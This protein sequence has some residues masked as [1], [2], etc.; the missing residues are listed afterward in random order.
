[1]HFIKLSQLLLHHVPVGFHRD[2]CAFRSFS[3]SSAA[4]K[5]EVEKKITRVLLFWLGLYLGV[6]V[7]NACTGMGVC[8]MFNVC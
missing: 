6:P 2:H 4:F 1:L 8:L 7:F 5:K 3:F